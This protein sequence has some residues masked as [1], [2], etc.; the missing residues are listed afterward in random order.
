M[1]QSSIVVIGNANVDLTTYVDSAPEEGETVIGHDFSIGMG[2]KGA[3]QA[4]AAARAGGSVSFIGRVGDDVFGRQVIDSLSREGLDLKNLQQIPGKSGIA[5][6]YVD[7]AGAN[8]IAVYPG[9][10]GTIDKEVARVALGNLANI[11]YLVSQLE[12][13]QTAVLAALETAHEQGA[14][15]LLNIAPYAPLVPGI[16]EN[17]DWLIANEGELGAL[18]QAHGLTASKD[19]SPQSLLAALSQWSDAV[20]CNIVVTL[21]EH[22]AVGHVLG[23]EPFWYVTPPVTAIDTVGAGDCFVGYFVAFLSQGLGWQQ[24]LAGG[25]LAASE[26]VQRAGAQSSYPDETDTQR[27]LTMVSPEPH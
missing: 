6:I 2:G 1:S 20:G 7:S 11:D 27:I 17:T 26:S 18:L 9:A 22:G 12:I 25:V 23:E 19:M 21:G 14:I 16:L 24:A 13:S 3:N 15:T 8:R 10:S 4:V 5:S